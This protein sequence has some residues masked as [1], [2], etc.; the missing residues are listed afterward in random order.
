MIDYDHPFIFDPTSLPPTGLWGIFTQQVSAK[1]E[2]RRSI[3]PSEG[4]FRLKKW[5]KMRHI[6]TLVIKKLFYY[7]PKYLRQIKIEVPERIFGFKFQNCSKKSTTLNPIWNILK[8]HSILSFLSFLSFLSKN[9]FSLIVI[10]NK[11]KRLRFWDLR[12]IDY[13]HAH[14]VR[15]CQISLS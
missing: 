4:K 3:F 12:Q 9:L 1:W 13:F 15:N 11:N 8:L 6:K 7:F 5:L 14:I 2:G 10:F